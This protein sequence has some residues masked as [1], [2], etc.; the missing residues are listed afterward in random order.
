MERNELVAPE[1]YNLTEEIEKRARARIKVEFYAADDAKK[2]EGTRRAIQY[3]IDTQRLILRTD[4]GH[5]D[6]EGKPVSYTASLG[7][8]AS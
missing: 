1:S 7:D 3:E 4:H 8:E 2:L 6:E 5:Y